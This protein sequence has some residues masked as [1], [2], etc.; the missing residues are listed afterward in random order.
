MVSAACRLKKMLDRRS[1]GIPE[2]ASASMVFSK[3][4]GVVAFAMASISALV[5]L[6]AR[7][8]AGI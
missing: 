3:V 1:I 2:N 7:S 8:N 4:A 5:L 6:M